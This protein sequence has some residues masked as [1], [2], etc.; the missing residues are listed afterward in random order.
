MIAAFHTN[1]PLKKLRSDQAARL[2]DACDSAKVYSPASRS[3]W[4]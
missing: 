1:S 3:G 2:D 4:N